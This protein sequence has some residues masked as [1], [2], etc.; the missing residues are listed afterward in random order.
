MAG[1]FSAMTNSLSYA[2]ILCVD[3]AADTASNS[4]G[5]N[6]PA[7][8]ELRN[9]QGVLHAIVSYAD[10]LTLALGEPIHLPAH[11]YFVFDAESI[12]VRAMQRGNP[13]RDC[14]SR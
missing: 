7:S 5:T 10:E 14:R 11:T 4:Y 3:K 1:L 12:E 2:A 6:L 13:G 9:T 8:N